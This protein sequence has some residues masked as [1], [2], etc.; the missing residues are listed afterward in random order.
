MLQL[1]TALAF[2][3]TLTA[4][5]DSDALKDKDGNEF[6]FEVPRGDE[7]PREGFQKVSYSYIAPSDDPNITVK[8][9]AKSERLER[10]P[11][12]LH[13]SLFI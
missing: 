10:Y 13:I 1:V 8:I 4:N 3:G 2:Y 12:L 7:L 9:N 6:R 11:P 5:P